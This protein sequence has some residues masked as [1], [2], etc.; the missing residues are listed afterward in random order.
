MDEDEKEPR[1]K[2]PFFFEGDVE[3]LRW[4]A[5]H[6]IPIDGTMATRARML[7]LANRIEAY[8]ERERERGVK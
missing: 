3:M 5:E 2:T 4:W 8:L 1:D 7:R 6:V